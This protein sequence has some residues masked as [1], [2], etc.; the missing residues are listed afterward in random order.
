MKIPL[1]FMLL[2]SLGGCHGS[3]DG[4][5][6]K[7]SS[8]VYV[9]LV[10]LSRSSYPTD[11]NGSG[12]GSAGYAVFVPSADAGSLP[13]LPDCSGVAKTGQCC[14]IAPP[15][16]AGNG[17]SSSVFL[18][19]W[20]VNVTNVT[21]PG[22]GS[23]SEI[24]LTDGGVTWASLTYVD[25]SG[26]DELRVQ[27]TAMGAVGAFSGQIKSPLDFENLSPSVFWDGGTVSIGQDLALRWMP[28]GAS[29]ITIEVLDQVTNGEILC[30][31]ADNGAFTIPGS[32][33]ANFQSG[34]NGGLILIRSAATCAYSDNASIS[35]QAHA[36]T[37]V[38][39]T[40]Q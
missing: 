32:L 21:E 37:L 39:A 18:S 1:R 14:Y 8:D 13:Q 31:V 36:L 26:G 12:P 28:G 22:S 30:T 40:F 34:D 23:Y 35:L 27:G 9:G 3:D 15:P 33:L 24:S 4:T 38:G 20:F 2:L 29:S 17:S 11:R 7:R 25:W 16:D 19:D 10:D 6:C 5:S